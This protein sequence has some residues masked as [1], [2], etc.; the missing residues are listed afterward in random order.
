MNLRYITFPPIRKFVYNITCVIVTQDFPEFLRYF[1]FTRRASR[2]NNAGHFCCCQVSLP[3]APLCFDNEAI[4]AARIVQYVVVRRDLMETMGWPMGALI[5]QACHASSAAI[6]LFYSE[7]STKDYLSD[8]DSMHKVVLQV[9]I[10]RPSVTVLS[11]L[12]G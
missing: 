5:T 3:I 8:L 9:D 1:L 6:H 2:E 7:Q 10:F 11:S 12:L 4:M